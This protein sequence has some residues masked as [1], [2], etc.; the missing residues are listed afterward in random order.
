MNKIN[1]KINNK[2]DNKI[3][4]K[5]KDK[6][7]NKTTVAFVGWDL[8]HLSGE[9]YTSCGLLSPWDLNRL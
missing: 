7:N 3:N 6:I 2:I 5:I 1:N 8:R 9:R 4:N